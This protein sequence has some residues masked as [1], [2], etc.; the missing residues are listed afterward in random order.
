[1]RWYNIP[2]KLQIV[3]CLGVSDNGQIFPGEMCLC[4]HSGSSDQ[5]RSMENRQEKFSAWD[6]SRPKLG[7]EVSYHARSHPQKLQRRIPGMVPLF[8]LRWVSTG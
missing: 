2:L 1:M 4:Q 8:L 5:H 7:G 3:L 6:T